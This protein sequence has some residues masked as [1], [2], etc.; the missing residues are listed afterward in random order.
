VSVGVGNAYTATGAA[1][2]H[3]P[4]RIYDELA[5]VL[6]AASPITLAN[7]VVLD[8]GAGTGAASR[9]IARAGGHPVAVDLALG[10]LAVDRVRRPPATVG[11]GRHL[12]VASHT[13]GAVVAA[14]SYNHVPDP[15]LAL[16]EAARVVIPGGAVAA[17]SYAADD[18]HPVKAAVDAAAA[19]A[20]WRPEP[21]LADL[22]AGS[23]PVLATV[24]GAAAVAER[25]GLAAHTR[26]IEV[27][28][29]HL[30]GQDL[31]AWRLGMASLAPFVASLPFAR[32]H[33]LEADALDRLGDPPML[34]RRIVVLTATT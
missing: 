2:Q 10:M 5:E 29:P 33:A 8:V 34:V 27:P 22:R 21:W 17:S 1:W 3:G 23:I 25:A 12:P 4:A 18:D 9:A 32:R 31:V 30:T 24:E 26:V 28:F 7:R 15:H 16:V 19:A 20:G 6:V 13:C 11:D 14:F